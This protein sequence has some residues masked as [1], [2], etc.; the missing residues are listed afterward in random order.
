MRSGAHNWLW[1]TKNYM[2][3]KNVR[4]TY[5]MKWER[6]YYAASSYRWNCEMRNCECE[7]IFPT[8]QPVNYVKYACVTTI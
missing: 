3:F 7:H 2:Y 6:Y 1:Y 8:S 4:V 5:R